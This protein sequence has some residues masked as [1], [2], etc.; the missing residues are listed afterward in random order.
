MANEYY[1]RYQLFRENGQV[2]NVPF[3]PIPEK[4]TDKK[5]IW[6]E[7]ISRLDKVSQQFYGVP[8]AGWLILQSN[9][10]LASLEGGFEDGQ[11]IRI[12]FPYRQT[13][14]QYHQSVNNY[15]KL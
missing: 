3:I 4:S 5:I 1:D 10:Y 13:I 2:K 6:R 15:L 11:I 7:G 12:P 8:T 14:E 9:S